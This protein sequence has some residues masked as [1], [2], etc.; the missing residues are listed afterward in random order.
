ML[1]LL[2]R[3]EKED[4]P[5]RIDR[6]YLDTLAGTDQTAL[7][8]ALKGFGLIGEQSDVKPELLRLAKDADNR[9]KMV[10]D[11]LQQYYPKQ[12]RLGEQNAT[13][14]MLEESFSEFDYSGDTKRKA[15]TFY[16]K[17]ADY[18]DVPLSAHFKIPKQ[19]SVGAARPKTPRQP[20]RR[21][22]TGVQEPPAAQ[23]GGLTP[24]ASTGPTKSVDLQSGGQVTLSYTADF[25]SLDNR[26][27]DFVLGLID[28][29]KAYD[30]QKSLPSEDEGSREMT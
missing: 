14:A 22:Q 10:A 6:S 3:M 16:L 7:M 28:A 9:P 24:P 25:F 21:R 19:R 17:A 30:D 20:R 8:A 13:H 29:L 1:N 12:V 2:F 11:L 4:P 23:T 5:P 26:D 18:A 27:R 15:V